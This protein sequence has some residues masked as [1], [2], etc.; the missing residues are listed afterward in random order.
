MKKLT[1]GFFLFTGVIGLLSAQEV[2]VLPDTIYVPDRTRNTVILLDNDI[3]ATDLLVGTKDYVGSV[4]ETGTRVFLRAAVSNPS[5]VA[6]LFFNYGDQVYNGYVAYKPSLTKDQ[7]M[8]DFRTPKKV[9]PVV[10]DVPETP[11]VAEVSYDK[12]KLVM[13]RNIGVM[14][15]KVKDR[16]DNIAKIGDKEKLIIKLAD[17]MQDSLDNLYVKIGLYNK[18]K[19]KYFID[20]FDFLYRNTENSK[21]YYQVQPSELTYAGAKEIEPKGS[22]AIIC[23]FP[24]YVITSKWVL[25]VKV[26]QESGA[27]DIEL[28]IPYKQISEA[29]KFK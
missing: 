23:V 24:K 14:E 19:D 28:D 18:A 15:G 9:E 27:R 25:R 29:I 3:Q 7:L 17:I 10:S 13:M 2:R 26:K 11:V 6:S 12:K 22:A 1:L 8:V 4:S 5:T 16:F 20:Y 21:E